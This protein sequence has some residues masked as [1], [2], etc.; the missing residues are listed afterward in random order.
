MKAVYKRMLEGMQKK[1]RKLKKRLKTREP[2]TLYIL[3][4]KDGTLYTGIAKDVDKRL[5]AH[6][7]GKGAKYTRARR[8]VSLLYQESCKSR[9]QALVRECAVKALPRNKKQDL[10]S[11]VS[12]SP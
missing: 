9:T 12:P 4:C 7:D 3:K 5:K 10:I 11:T 1:E 2:W 8:P 6:N